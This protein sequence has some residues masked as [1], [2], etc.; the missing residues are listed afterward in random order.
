MLRV[1]GADAVGMSTVPECIA[2]NHL[3]VE[4]GALI[5]ISNLAAGMQSS[6]LHHQ[7][8][9]DTS[10]TTTGKIA[11]MLKYAL[12][13]LNLGPKSAEPSPGP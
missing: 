12:P 13:R 3:G 11:E 4:V 9:I 6:K 8:V 7:E 10:K 2:A 5:S 1:L